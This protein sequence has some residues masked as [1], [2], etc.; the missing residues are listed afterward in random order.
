MKVILQR[1]DHTSIFCGTR[2]QRHSSLLGN[3]KVVK[4]TI[5]C[6]LLIIGVL[7]IIVAQ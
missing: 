7:I 2:I 6:A 4:A 1:N 3:T 5:A